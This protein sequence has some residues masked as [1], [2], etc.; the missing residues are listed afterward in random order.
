MMWT[1]SARFT[2]S[3]IAASVVDFP[4]P[5]GPVTRTSPRGLSASSL[6]TGGMASSSRVRMALG[7]SRKAPASFPSWRKTLTRNLAAPGSA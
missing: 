1:G 6:T 5:V 3:T 2:S 7:I 4:E